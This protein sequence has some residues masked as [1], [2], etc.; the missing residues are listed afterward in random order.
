MLSKIYLGLLAFSVLIVGF[1]TYYSWSWLRSIGVPAAAVEGFVY[2]SE[3]AW[4]VLWTTFALLLIVGNGILWS[5]KSSWAVWMSFV[6]FAVFVLVRYFWLDAAALNFRKSAG[7]VEGTFS[8]G[9]L[10]GVIIVAAAAAIVFLDHFVV[11][12]LNQ[13]MFPDTKTVETSPEEEIEE[14]KHDPS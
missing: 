13:R 11:V 6:Y 4:Y 3:T 12:R 1:F 7:L 2:N 8:L 5:S 10:L 9:P 14:V